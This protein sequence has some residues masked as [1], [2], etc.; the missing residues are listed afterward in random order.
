VPAT[1]LVLFLSA[2]GLP[3]AKEG[4]ATTTRLFNAPVTALISQLT[5]VK[6]PPSL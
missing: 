2:L 4:G 1:G 5:C 6:A 3:L